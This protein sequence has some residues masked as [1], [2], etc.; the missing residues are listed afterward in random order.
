MDYNQ[1]NYF[2][3]NIY[4]EWLTLVYEAFVGTD[5]SVPSSSILGIWREQHNG[6][7]DWDNDSDG[8][9][10]HMYLYLN[11]T[12]G[13]NN[14]NH[15]HIYKNID[16]NYMWH[17]TCGRRFRKG[18]VN[19]DEHERSQNLKEGNNGL[20]LGF[21]NDVMHNIINQGLPRFRFLLVNCRQTAISSGWQ[22]LNQFGGRKKRKKKYNHSSRRKTKRRRKK[23]RRKKKRKTRRRKRHRRRR[24]RKHRQREADEVCKTNKQ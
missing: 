24:T 18:G 8:F 23:R 13:H 7:G 4:Q 21:G 5:A 16:N 20:L 12:N 9:I 19:Q 14:K 15:I 11:D 17:L 1:G 3:H 10:S 2:S 6:E 22:P